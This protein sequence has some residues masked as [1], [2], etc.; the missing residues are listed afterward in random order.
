MSTE[1]AVSVMNTTEE[2][3]SEVMRNDDNSNI[4]SAEDIADETK[5]RKL[6]GDTTS[7]SQMSPLERMTSASQSHDDVEPVR[8][9]QSQTPGDAKRTPS[10]DQPSWAGCA[11]WSDEENDMLYMLVEENKIGGIVQSW[12]HIAS[13]FG[14]RSTTACRQHW[15]IISKGR[16]ATKWENTTLTTNWSRL[17]ETSRSSVRRYHVA[18]RSDPIG[19]ITPASVDTAA[20]PV[21]KKQKTQAMPMPTHIVGVCA[22]D[23]AS[24][25]NPAP[26]HVGAGIATAGNVTLWSDVENRELLL[27]YLCHGCEWQAAH[28]RV[29]TRSVDEINKQWYSVI[30][31]CIKKFF[32]NFYHPMRFMDPNSSSKSTVSE[33]AVAQSCPLYG[34]SDVPFLIQAVRTS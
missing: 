4:V 18:V 12:R 14:G 27:S 32:V 22:P 33:E 17:T 6:D 31:P 30:S 34:V 26:T 15:N 11:V 1:T 13:H 16:N 10:R 7:I 29:V 21:P 24:A 28:K 19:G 8:N 5:K 3:P 20:N 25:P 9:I 23:S 2:F